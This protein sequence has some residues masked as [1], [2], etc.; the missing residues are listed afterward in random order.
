[1]PLRPCALLVVL[2]ST[3][4]FA[5]CAPRTAVRSPEYTMHAGIEGVRQHPL[6]MFGMPEHGR[7]W[8][9]GP[10]QAVSREG[11]VLEHSSTDKIPVWV[12]EHVLSRHLSGA[13]GRS[14]RF[15]PD[16]E[17]PAGQRAELADYRGSGYDRGHQAPAGDF[18]YSQTRKDESFYLSN[19]CPQEG[20][21]FNQ[22]I[23]R[24]LEDRT[25]AV[26]EH[27]GEAFIIT[28]SLFWDPD[29][30]DERTA[31]GVI[32][33][34]VIGPGRVAV[35]T[36]F[37]KIIVAPDLSAGN[38]TQEHWKVIAFVLGNR[39]YPRQAD[40]AYDFTPFVQ[41]IDWIEDHAG[42]NFMPA[43]DADSPTL[44]EALE[45][46]PSPTWPEYQRQ[47]R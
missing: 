33:Y 25:R 32:N 14:N 35:P 41:S 11:Y 10:T 37:Y 27:H 44:E 43:L 45:R 17:L 12:C 47:E 40:S 16:P 5:G 9:G 7:G 36:H 22:S 23:W 19:M 13:A 20:P 24:V 42:L 15:K 30:D 29:E 8:L 28:G 26:V 3:E 31:D 39:D 46:R 4:W 21:G 1:M 38:E 18:D 6:C 34:F 2:L